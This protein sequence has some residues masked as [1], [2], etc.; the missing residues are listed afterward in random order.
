MWWEVVK[1]K[2]RLKV[3]PTIKIK[4]P[5]ERTPEDCCKEAKERWIKYTIRTGGFDDDM[6]PRILSD[7]SCDKFKKYLTTLTSR[8]VQE[9]RVDATVTL[10]QWKRCEDE[11]V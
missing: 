8:A 5:K 10:R 2:P 9:L 7:R 11:L 3:A 6:M 4:T 1:I